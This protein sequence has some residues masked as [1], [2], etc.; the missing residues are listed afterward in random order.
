MV[1]SKASPPYV[2]QVLNRELAYGATLGEAIQGSR[3][4][5]SHVGGTLEEC[6]NVYTCKS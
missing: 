3:S 4:D 6:K 2:Y 5:H 1:E